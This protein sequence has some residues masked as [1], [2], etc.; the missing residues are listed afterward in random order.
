MMKPIQRSVK[1][2]LGTGC[3][4]LASL[5]S[6]IAA[7]PQDTIPSKHQAAL[8][9]EQ[10]LLARKLARLLG[11]MERLAERFEAEGRIHAAKLL[12]DGLTHARTRGT[13]GE[14]SSLE[15][16]MSTARAELSADQSMQSIQTQER[17]IADLERLLS[18]LMDRPD[19]EELENSLE[20]LRRFEAALAGLIDDERRLQEETEALREEASG[21]AQR[22]LEE[23]I[24]AAIELQRELLRKNEEEARASGALD[25]EK[26]ERQLSE[27]LEDQHT[28]ARVLDSWNPEGLP[29]LE[30]LSPTL[31]A[32]RRA[33]AETGRL[34][35]AAEALREAAEASATE[36]ESAGFED[37][38][39]ELQT[40]AEKEERAGRA[41]GN[42]RTRETARRLEQAAGRLRDA[43][44][45]E[46]AREDAAREVGELA[47]E[48]GKEAEEA[49]SRAKALRDEAREALSELSGN[50]ALDEELAEAIEAELAAAEEDPAEAD[51]ALER[52]SR[53]LNRGI[54]D[55]KFLGPALSASQRQNAERSEQ[56]REGLGRLD[57]ELAEKT[58]GARE[59]LGQANEAMQEASERA[60]E[61]DQQGAKGAASEAEEALREALAALSETRQEGSGQGTEA[62]ELAREQEQLAEEVEALEELTEDASMDEAA[63]EVVRDELQEAS[64]AM[65]E[66][67]EEMR[68]NKSGAAAKAQRSAG[69]AL[70]RA[71]QEAREGVTP[72]TPE[73]QERAEELAR[74]QERIEKELYEFMKRYQE[75]EDAQP[76]PGIDG[77]QEAA[78]EAQEALKSGELDEAQ[79]AEEEAERQMEQALRDL[80]DE[81]EQYQSLRDEELLFQIAQEVASILEAHRGAA[82]ETLE[83]DAVRQE[84]ARPSR[85]QRARLRKI[86]RQEEALANRATEIGKALTEEGSIVFAELIERVDHDLRR[87]ASDMSETGGYQSG[88]RVQALQADVI[89]SLNWLEEAL[90][91]EKQRREEQQKQDQPPPGENR[92]VPDVAELKLLGRME[93]DVLDAID[94]LLIIYPELKEAEGID[95]LLLEE[96]GRLAHRH[97]RTSELFK[98]FRERLGLPAPNLEAVEEVVPTEGEGDT[99]RGSETGD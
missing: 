92:L 31:E 46:A 70:R 76:L 72:Q 4:V 29:P 74:E 96:I 38:I 87:V 82:E 50:S 62:E 35:R 52:A 13:E 6:V 24:D 37:E 57:E 12:R 66:A 47:A 89:T 9:E 79:Q 78:Q 86:S 28:D 59:K 22:S 2:L 97:Q 80:K 40:L 48:L 3:L 18:I 17:V 33:Q 42:E 45:D 51:R 68:R 81:E 90:E 1:L 84:G 73:Q 58:A 16:L 60:A 69:E 8:I 88:E 25:L 27:L 21:E 19:L 39:R 7:A 71:A 14:T 56:I 67:S 44:E 99:E 32:A 54:D 64:E 11:S 83:V 53:A 63:Q 93:R 98:V 43:G 91:E 95:P 77:A 65:R 49:D 5:S 36:D 30:Q 23:A 20:E 26:L 61:Q 41:S 75:R 55:L 85:G 15:E 10:E 34:Q 94:E